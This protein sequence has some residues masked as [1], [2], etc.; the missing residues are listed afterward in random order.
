MA[1]SAEQKLINTRESK[2]RWAMNNRD[3]IKASTKEW[4]LNNPEKYKLGQ[5]KW[6]IKSKYGLEWDQYLKLKEG[7]C[8]IC[9]TKKNLHVDHDHDKPGT[10]RGILCAKH[11]QG[12][13]YLGD[14][15][16]AIDEKVSE[17]KNYLRRAA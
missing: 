12:L 13:G 4:R 11:N 3:K 10:Y 14:N 16:E 17:Y 2:R 7:G 6:A 9:K 8:E 5:K 1:L 15:L